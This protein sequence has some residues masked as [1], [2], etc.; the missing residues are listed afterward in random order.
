MPEANSTEFIQQLKKRFNR[1]T[2]VFLLSLCLSGL[3]WLLTSLSK[4][5]V[6]VIQVPITY[7]NLPQDM[8]V[9]NEL[10]DHL[11]VEVKTFGFDLL[12]Y[13]FRP[14]KDELP[15][16][17]APSRLRKIVRDGEEVHIFLLDER[18]NNIMSELDEQFQLLDISPD[19]LFIM[20]EPIFSKKVP[21][22]LNAEISFV[23]QFGMIDNPHLQPD[24]VLVTGRKEVIDTMQFVNTE[25]EKWHD[26]S[27]SV[28]TKLN[29]EQIAES[30]MTHFSHS[31]VDVELNVVEF[32][33]GK[34]T[35]PVQVKAKNSEKVTVYPQ[36]VDI[37]FNVPLDAYE[38]VRSEQFQASVTLTNR[39]MKSASR[40]VVN[41]D[42]QPSIVKQVKVNPPQVEFIIQR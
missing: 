41:I 29:L 10:R 25:A 13:W 32:T 40:L 27:E 33:E 34:V 2:V 14:D 37:T 11:D 18:K 39:D 1:K 22:R 3:F 8:L 38:S 36:K 26:L 6:E 31:E 42:E 21:V 5:Y 28:T 24:S 16:D 12:W 9:V 35:V 15:I 19:T 23:K 17:A 30:G 20:L 4:N 7:K